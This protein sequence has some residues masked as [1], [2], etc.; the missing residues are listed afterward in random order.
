MSP[1]Y[2]DES[3]VN[4][5]IDSKLSSAPSAAAVAPEY[6]LPTYISSST[7]DLFDGELGD[8]ELN[9]RF[10]SFRGACFF[11]FTLHLAL[12]IISILECSPTLRLLLQQKFL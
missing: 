2:T 9:G 4:Q 3:F 7:T 8:Y 5:R 11:V 10:H 1:Y 12:L 6:P